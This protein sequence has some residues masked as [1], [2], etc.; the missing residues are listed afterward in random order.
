MKDH[1]GE[2][3]ENCSAGTTVRTNR[4]QNCTTTTPTTNEHKALK[5]VYQG[6]DDEGA[7]NKK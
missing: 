4:V 1:S 7:K 5:L 3:H 6:A 2:S